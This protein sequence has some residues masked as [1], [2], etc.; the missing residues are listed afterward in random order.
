M[1]AT[2][3]S[4][5]ARAA[6]LTRVAQEGGEKVVEH[7]NNGGRF[8]RYERQVDPDGVLAPDERYRR[9]KAAERADMVRLA[10]RSAAK[11]RKQQHTA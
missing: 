4:A 1:N 11:R 2:E 7:L 5:N 10:Q 3:R 9:A 6:A 8:A